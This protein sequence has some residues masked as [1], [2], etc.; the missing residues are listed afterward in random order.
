MKITLNNAGKRFNREWIFRHVTATYIAGNAYAITGP[1]GSGK[2]TFLQTLSGNLNVNEGSVN[3]F[4]G[5]NKEVNDDN[6]YNHLSICA[7]YI[8]LVEEMTLHEF[9]SFHFCFKPCIPGVTM[10]E[11][12]SLIGLQDAQQKQMR[13]YSSGMKQRVRLA[14]AI[15]SNVPVLLLD[16]PCT[17]F[18]ESGYTLYHNLISK[19]CSHKLIM[20]SSNDAREYSFCNNKLNLTDHK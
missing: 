8:D 6:V 16:E 17:N 7:P 10:Q 5:E 13:Y 4:L 15:F 20:V 19:Y 9:L 1:N 11:I 18:D 12:S 3:Y 14:Q 2:S